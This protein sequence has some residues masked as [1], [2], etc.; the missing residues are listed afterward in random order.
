MLLKRILDRPADWPGRAGRAR[1]YISWTAG[2]WRPEWRAA[3]LRRTGIDEQSKPRF[4]PR[5]ARSRSVR[6]EPKIWKLRLVLNSS[7]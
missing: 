4:A 1:R 7:L 3:F 2:S 6:T 5:T